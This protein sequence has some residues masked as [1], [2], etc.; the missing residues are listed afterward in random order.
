MNANKMGYWFTSNVG[1]GI[2]ISAVLFVRSSDSCCVKAN[3][4]L[5]V[6]WTIDHI[7]SAKNETKTETIET[8]QTE[9]N[10]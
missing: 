6:T 3:V 9:H 10:R 2:G 5:S 7:V 1:F 4:P 8:I